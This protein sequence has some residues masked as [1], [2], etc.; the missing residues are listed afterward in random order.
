MACAAEHADDKCDY[1]TRTFEGNAK[2]DRSTDVQSA[3]NI[4][5]MHY[6]SP[7]NGE[8]STQWGIQVQVFVVCKRKLFV[9]LCK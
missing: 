1:Y 5:Y 3:P 9:V 7:I 6:I 4:Y 2:G 8:E